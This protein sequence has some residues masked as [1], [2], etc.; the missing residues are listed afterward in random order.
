MAGHRRITEED[1]TRVL[2][3][4]EKGWSAQRIV[5]HLKGTEHELTKEAVG[6]VLATAR[7]RDK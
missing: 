3:L 2:Q 1:R 6:M 7:Y 4:S 5:Q